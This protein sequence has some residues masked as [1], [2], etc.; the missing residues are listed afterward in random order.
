[1]ALILKDRDWGSAMSKLLRAS[2]LCIVV[3]LTLGLTQH[4]GGA[5]ELRFALVIGNDEYRTG[6]LATPR[7]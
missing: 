5:A 4:A 7:Q 3:C 6:K 1:M 2:L